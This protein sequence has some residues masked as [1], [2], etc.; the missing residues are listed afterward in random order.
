[1]THFM[2]KKLR[3]NLILSQDIDNQRIIQPDCMKANLATADQTTAFSDAAF[4]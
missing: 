3:Y 2:H 1:M 4:A